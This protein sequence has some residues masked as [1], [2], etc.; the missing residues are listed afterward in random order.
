[1]PPSTEPSTPLEA[2]R[3]IIDQLAEETSTG[4]SERLLRT[5]G[6]YS[7][8]PSQSAAN[9][10]ARSLTPSQRDL[11]ADMLRHERVGAIH[12]ALAVLTWL[13]SCRD[14]SLGFRG[15]PMSEDLTSGEG[16]HGDY[17]GRCQGWQWPSGGG[18]PEG[19]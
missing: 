12:D 15:Q 19:A 1:M 8:A 5:S 4:V 3:A 16:F 10:F 2:Y 7:K 17:I 6:I 11:L 13:V 9:D 14:V 18:T